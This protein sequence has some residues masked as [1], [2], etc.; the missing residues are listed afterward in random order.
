MRVR[1]LSL[2]ENPTGCQRHLVKVCVCSASRSLPG[3]AARICLP[4]RRDG[5]LLCDTIAL[6]VRELAGLL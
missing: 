3:S 6:R 2:V 1:T 5:L 4:S